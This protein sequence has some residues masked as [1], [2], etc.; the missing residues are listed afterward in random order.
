MLKPPSKC[1]VLYENFVNKLHEKPLLIYVSQDC[2]NLGGFAA[3][4]LG[5][6]AA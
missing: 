6:T 2:W 4:A 5:S 1:T 3:C